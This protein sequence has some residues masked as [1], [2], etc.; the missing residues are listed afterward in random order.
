VHVRRVDLDAVREDFLALLCPGEHARAGRLLSERDRKRWASARGVLRTLLGRYLRT[1]ARRLRFGALTHGRPV[2]LDD[3][4]ESTG[5]PESASVKSAQI[6]F[7]LSHSGRLALYAFSR[8][9]TVGIDVEVARRPRDEVAIAARA[10]GR[11]DARRLEGL[12]PAE[13]ERVFLR[14]WVRHEAELKYRGTGIVGGSA[15]SRERQPRIAELPVGHG[16]AAAVA[17]ERSPFDLCCWDWQA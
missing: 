10:F 4:T 11:D 13:R 15:F 3:A 8:T 16:A 6:S 1:D 14:A 5:A 9:G 17:V 12:G 2:L 7:N